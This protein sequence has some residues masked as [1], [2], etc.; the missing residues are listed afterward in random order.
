LELNE[1]GLVLKVFW[2]RPRGWATGSFQ[3]KA[4]AWLARQ[5]RA[6]TTMTLGWIARRLRMGGWTYVLNV[7]RE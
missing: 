7:L 4:R 6:E 3:R 2:S 1:H 5:L